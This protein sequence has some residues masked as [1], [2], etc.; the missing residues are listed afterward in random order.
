MPFFWHVMA[1]QLPTPLWDFICKGKQSVEKKHVCGIPI[2]KYLVWQW[3][4]C[5]SEV[6]W[7]QLLM[8]LP[9]STHECQVTSNKDIYSHSLTYHNTEA[10][11]QLNNNVN[12]TLACFRCWCN[13]QPGWDFWPRDFPVGVWWLDQAMVHPHYAGPLLDSGN[14]RW[15]T[16]L[17][18]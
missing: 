3:G 2:W 17:W 15:H 10:G 18:W 9:I 11:Q 7:I 8:N 13:S 6:H 12:L 16:G 1:Y 5:N 4:I 14:W